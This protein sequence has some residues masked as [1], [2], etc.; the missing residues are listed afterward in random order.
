M[1]S[2]GIGQLRAAIQADERG[3]KGDA[4]ALYARAVTMLQAE[5]QRASNPD[6]AAALLVGASVVSSTLTQ[7][8]EAQKVTQ[9]DRDWEC[10]DGRRR[11]GEKI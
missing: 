3:D 1:A 2:S 5:A 10:V 8:R 7:C 9:D 6:D 11:R 4:A